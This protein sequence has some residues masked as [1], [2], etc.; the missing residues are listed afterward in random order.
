MNIKF[1]MPK[2]QR[3]LTNRSM[4]KELLLTFLGTTISIV[5]TFGTAHLLDIRQRVKDRKM[6]ALMVMGNVE[7][8]ARVLDDLADDLTQ[9]DTI[10]T[11]LLALPVDSLE[12]VPHGQ[13][14]DAVNAVITFPQL[15]HDRTAENIFS[16]SIETWKNMGNFNFIDRVG[17]NFA[18]INECEKSYNDFIMSS[19]KHVD[20]I[21]RHPN[22]FRGDDMC[23]KCMLDTEFRDNI[24]EIHGWIC[25]LR[26]LAASFRYSN[27][28]SMSMIGITEEDVMSFADSSNETTTVD[29]PEPLYQS[30]MTPKLK[31][32]S[33]STMPGLIDRIEY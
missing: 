22:N 4:W 9:R 29:R 5:L 18:E 1:K 16:N 3:T 12:S 32:D 7:R 24:G 28:K 6:S 15:S 20:W 26:F 31:F 11:W 21:K 33:L 14:V 8:F 30:F 27:L 2:F 13:M 19:A 10:A 25:Y 17:Q 23:M